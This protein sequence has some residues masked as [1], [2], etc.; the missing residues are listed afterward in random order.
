M[1]E[2]KTLLVISPHPDDL[3]IGMGGT[4]AQE[5]FLGNKVISV[6][7]TDGRR[8]QRSFKCSD[9][10]MAEIRKNEVEAS[11]SLLGIQVLH[12]LELPDLYLFENQETL[13]KELGKILVKY[14]PNAI[15]LPHPKLDR[16]P[17]H[18]LGAELV[19]VLIKSLTEEKLLREVTLWAY[20]VWGLFPTWD[21]VV[22]ISGFIEQKKAAINC[23]KSQITDINYTEGILGLNR[24][25]AVFNDPHKI[26]TATYLE[27]FISL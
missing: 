19:L 12:C 10:K 25:R 4:V 1:N 11:T 5:I 26:S 6:V 15:Y 7:L 18:S 3:E 24:W 20:E 16:H 17:S 23:H 14:Q 2:A 21:L 9:E 8:S 27:V 22:D 13:R